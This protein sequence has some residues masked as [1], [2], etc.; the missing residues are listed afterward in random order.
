MT[1]T[2]AVHGNIQ[3][4]KLSVEVM[5]SFKA[6]GGPEGSAIT[7]KLARHHVSRADIYDP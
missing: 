2:Q 7:I 6:V 4:F 3:S 1:T 5:R